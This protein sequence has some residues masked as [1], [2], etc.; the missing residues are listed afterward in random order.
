MKKHINLTCLAMVSLSLS[1]CASKTETETKESVVAPTTKVEKTE[2]HVQTQEET[3]EMSTQETTRITKA[4]GLCYEIVKNAENSNTSTPSLGQQVTVH[5]TGWL[6][7]ENG[8]RGTKFDSSVD[9]GQSFSFIIGIGQVIK[10]WD[11]G[12]M[13][14]KV[15]EKRTLIIPAELG[16]GNRGSGAT[17]PPGATLIFDVELLAVS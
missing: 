10:G 17:I 4:S 1:S 6:E 2:H 5:Y 12:V 16:Y 15:G 8:E 11:E 14:M 3:K 9:R 7:K 13:D